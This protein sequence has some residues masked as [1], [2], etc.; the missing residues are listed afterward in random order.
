M[1]FNV[2]GLILLGKSTGNIKFD[3]ASVNCCHPSL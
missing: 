3:G 1:D 2:T